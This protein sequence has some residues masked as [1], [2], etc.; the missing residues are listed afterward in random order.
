MEARLEIMGFSQKFEHK[1][2]EA[3]HIR[4]ADKHLIDK[5]AKRRRGVLDR[6]LRACLGWQKSGLNPLET[7]ARLA[8]TISHQLAPYSPG[9]K[10]GGEGWS[11]DT[12]GERR[13][14][15]TI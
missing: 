6:P 7:C 11:F 9:S 13:V 8:I 4:K 10:S 15:V 5:R 14:A 2:H 12:H 1:D 3:K